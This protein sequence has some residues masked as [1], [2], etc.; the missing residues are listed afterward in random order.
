MLIYCLKILDVSI[1]MQYILKLLAIIGL[2]AI[3]TIGY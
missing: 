3:E 2:Y 1:D